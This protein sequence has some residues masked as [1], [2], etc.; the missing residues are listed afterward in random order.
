[1][2]KKLDE[3]A[4]EE[5]KEYYRLWRMKNKSKVKKHNSD[6]WKRKAERKLKDQEE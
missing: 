5:R 4:K 3:L 2:L 1:M 6:Y